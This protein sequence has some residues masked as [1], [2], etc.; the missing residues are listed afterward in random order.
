MREL[1]TNIVVEG[2]QATRRKPLNVLVER[3]NEH[4]ERQVSLELRCRPAEHE[5]PTPISPGRKLREKP[6]L[7][8]PR[9]THQRNR[10]GLATVQIDEQI[11]ENTA[12][13]GAPNEV[14]GDRDHFRSRRA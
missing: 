5:V 11:I 14:L 9:L 6:R 13:C 2:L 7:A 10:S 3:V 8:N 12:R 1:T 4:P